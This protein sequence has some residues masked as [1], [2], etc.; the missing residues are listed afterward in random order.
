MLM[1]ITVPLHI[2]GI[3]IGLRD[4]MLEILTRERQMPP[5]VD[6]YVDIYAWKKQN[7]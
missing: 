5:Y 2:A 7:V 3:G 4:D 1:N 6:T